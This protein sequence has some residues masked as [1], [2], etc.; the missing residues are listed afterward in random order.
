ML[1]PPELLGHFGLVTLTNY[2]A[3]VVA[4][5]LFPAH[6]LRT[7]PLG[8]IIECVIGSIPWIYS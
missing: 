2:H 5:R 3:S 1:L 6:D 4:V 8:Q 7:G